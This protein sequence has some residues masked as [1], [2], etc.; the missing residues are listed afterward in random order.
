M[1]GSG[2]LFVAVLFAARQ[3]LHRSSRASSSST[4]L[5]AP[6]RHIRPISR[7]RALRLRR[8]HGAV[9]ISLPRPSVS[10][11]GFYRWLVVAGYACGLIFMFSVTSKR[12]LLLQL[13]GSGQC[14]P[15]GCAAAA[16]ASRRAERI[17]TLSTPLSRRV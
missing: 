6:M 15:A 12:S 5:R 13:G 4:S 16:D 9:F 7:I 1:L 14:D 8:P 10:A 11:P 2:I 17:L 3:P